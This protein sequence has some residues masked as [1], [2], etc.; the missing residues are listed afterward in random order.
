[1]VLDLPLN[2]VYSTNNFVTFCLGYGFVEG[3][4]IH[5]KTY[6]QLCCFKM[7]FPCGVGLGLFFLSVDRSFVC[8]NAHTVRKKGVPNY[9]QIQAIIGVCVCVCV[10]VFVCECVCIYTC[11]YIHTLN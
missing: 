7:E 6:Q 11:I 1:M 10:F 2:D 3:G 4:K 5:V 8:L 9:K